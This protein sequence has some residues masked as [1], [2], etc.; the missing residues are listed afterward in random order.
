M[1]KDLDD[2]VILDII[3]DV[4]LPQ[5]RYPEDLVLISLLEVC[6]EGGHQE[7]GTWRTLRVPDRRHGGHIWSIK[8][9]WMYLVVQGSYPK[10][11]V[12]LS[13]SLAEI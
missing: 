10:S 12:S 9:L 11:F 6:Q 7:G 4:F 3:N 5:G 13:L 2:M 1:T 8:R